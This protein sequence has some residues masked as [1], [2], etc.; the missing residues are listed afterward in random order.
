MDIQKL[1]QIIFSIGKW[2]EKRLRLFYKT[3]K[4]LDKRYNILDVGG[5]SNS[6]ISNYKDFKKITLL[7]LQK[8]KNIPMKN[9]SSIKG[10]GR[11]LEFED[12]K[13]DIV[14][15]NS[16]IEHVGSF[17]DQKNFAKEAMRVGKK[18]WIQTPAKEFFFEPHFL[19]PF[20]HWLPIAIRKIIIYITPWYLINWANKKAIDEI[21]NE[22]RILSKNEIK[23]L[24]PDCEIVSEKFLF[25]TKSYI[26]IRN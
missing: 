6:W 4:P 17:E 2:R 9:I 26:I 12:K 8:E 24:F 18:I 1:F 23:S 15:S 22:I 13:F 10:D 25:F 19:F 16:V 20:F 3:F 21:I 14:F 7:N 5:Y 11:K